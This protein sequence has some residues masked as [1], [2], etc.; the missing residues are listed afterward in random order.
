[1]FVT[2]YTKRK[3]YF[4]VVQV[5]NKKKSLINVLGRLFTLTGCVFKTDDILYIISLA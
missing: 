3:M 1:M 2:K 5:C 4:N